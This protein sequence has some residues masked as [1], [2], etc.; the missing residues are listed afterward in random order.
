MIIIPM[1]GKSS[2]F[3]KEGYSEPK[4]KLKVGELTVFEKAVMSFEKYFETD[5]F[6]FLVRTDYSASIFVKDALVKLGVK[7]FLIVEFTDETEGQAD[8]VY[9]GL[10]KA[11]D[12]Y[13][14]QEPIYI[15]N[16]DTFRP[17]FKKSE[18]SIN[19][20]YLEVFLGEG[21]HWSFALPGEN[22]SVLKTTEK[23]RISNLCSNGLY[24]FKTPTLFKTAFEHSFNNDLRE[25]GEFYIAP[26]YNYLIQNGNSVSYEIIPSEDI[27]FCGTPDEY[28]SIISSHS[29]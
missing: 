18:K 12:F 20:G 15:F 14:N 7:N 24:Y 19:D 17:N 2:R 16:I 26:L 27:I 29:N 5:K 21:T 28:K 4:Y 25:K 11:A 1:V 22:H 23:D 10:L 8:T 3:F 6:L 13:N 9:Q